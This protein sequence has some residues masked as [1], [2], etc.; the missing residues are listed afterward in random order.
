M[1]Y[2]EGLRLVFGTEA[3]EDAQEDVAALVQE[4]ASLLFRVA[5]AVLREPHE[6]EDV[7]QDTFLRVL[8]HRH[9]LPELR[10]QRVWLVRIA[11]N[12]ALDRR[13]RKRPEQMDDVFA[14][15][16]AAHLAPADQMLDETERL[17]NALRAI[18]G[19]PTAERSAL[20]LSAVDEMTH[21]EIAAVLGKSESAV[22]ALLFRARTRLR[23]R[24]Q[25]PPT[26]G[27]K[28]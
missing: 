5:H 13:K 20:L 10:D 1:A 26:K 22:R 3:R 2:A 15:T 17:R 7:V 16:L 27:G 18:D 21:T 19:L 25:P 23:E 4:H 12:L 9:R 8:H 14:G 28:R 11:W 24:L 6:A